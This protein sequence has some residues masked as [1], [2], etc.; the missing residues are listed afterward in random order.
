MHDFYIL[1]WSLFVSVHFM[2]SGG[3]KQKKAKLRG[4]REMAGRNSN[5]EQKNHT[6]LKL[7][8]CVELSFLKKKT[9][10]KV[11]FEVQFSAVQ[12]SA[13][14]YSAMQCTALQCS[15]LHCTAV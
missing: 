8:K 9:F 1:Y 10:F 4:K 2:G 3:N 6:F 15:A 11:C 14:Q 7:F 5:L 12:C 13:V